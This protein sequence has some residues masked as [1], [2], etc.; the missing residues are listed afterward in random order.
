M[1]YKSANQRD[2]WDGEKDARV[3]LRD[4]IRGVRAIRGSLP[5]ARASIPKSLISRIGLPQVVDF[6][7]SFTYFSWFSSRLFQKRLLQLVDFH[8]SFR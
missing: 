1:K 2:E 6:H 4:S 8:D 7:D 3:E 5:R